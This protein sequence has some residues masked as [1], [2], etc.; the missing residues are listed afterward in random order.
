MAKKDEPLADLIGSLKF[1][2]RHRKGLSLFGK[3]IWQDNTVPGLI[4]D[5][6]DNRG[7]VTRDD[8]KP[9]IIHRAK[10]EYGWRLMVNLPPGFC[11]SDV[12]RDKEYFE[13]ATDSAIEMKWLNGNVYMEVQTGRLPEMTN[14]ADF[15]PQKGYIPLCIGISR[16]GPAFIDL[17][18]LPHF[19]I[20]GV[21]GFGKST[22]LRSLIH[23]LL[24]RA[25]IAIIDLK[26]VDFNYLQ[27]VVLL[28]R[29]PKESLQLVRAIEREY[30]RRISL[31]E[32]HRVSHIKEVPGD[33]QPI[34]LVVDEMAEVRKYDEVFDVFDR[35]VRM[36]RASGVSVVAASQRT[37]TK[38]IDG[39]CRENFV[40]R[41][42]FQT[43]TSKGSEVILGEGC[44]QAARLPGIKGRG[45]YHQSNKF[46]EVQTMYLPREDAIKQLE[47]IP[48]LKEGISYGPQPKTKRLPPR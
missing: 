21:T 20:G 8:R 42:A 40:G 48:I 31:V 6:F 22:F 15:G 32:D 37:S 5:V 27:D 17:G 28:A 13:A 4:L 44:T 33:H 11:F 41:L 18:E 45:I 9:L 29:H 10:T 38:V 23:Q 34:V 3:N 7:Y 24:G 30:E 25:L 36:A 2:W 35:L 47:S 26:R 14:Y 19:L 12:W 43:A 39:D 16:S 1:T 46:I